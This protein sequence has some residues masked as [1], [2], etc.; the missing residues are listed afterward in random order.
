[1]THTAYILFFTI[2]ILALVAS[3]GYWSYRLWRTKIRHWQTLT[4]L[5]VLY[6]LSIL[7]TGTFILLICNEKDFHE[8]FSVN[9][10]TLGIL[11][12]LPLI[13]LLVK[14]ITEVKVPSTQTCLFHLFP[15]T[16][17]GGFCAFL[18]LSYSAE[19]IMNT[20]WMN[21][22]EVM[23][24]NYL[25]LF[26]SIIGSALIIREVIKY[27]REVDSYFADRKQT[28]YPC[29][30]RMSHAAM[31]NSVMVYTTVLF[32][33]WVCMDNWQLT[34]IIILFMCGILNYLGRTLTMFK[35]S[36]IP[37]DY[38]YS[39][40]ALSIVEIEALE[41][42]FRQAKALIAAENATA[43]ISMIIKEWTEAKNPSYLKTGITLTEAAYEM[44]IPASILSNYINK[45]LDMNFNQWINSFRLK[46]VKYLLITTNKTLDEIAAASGFATRNLLSR[47][48]K[49]H[50]GITPSE[51]RSKKKGS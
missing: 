30:Q 15:T 45:T 12:V 29:V 1:M 7:A 35:G 47:T 2:C 46:H 6:A 17:Y 38:D 8:S 4:V 32:S 9:M 41:N 42:K 49:V 34:G 10:L 21:Q 22:V 25:L 43:N 11:Y 3:A 50:E 51:F 23:L 24:Y 33:F 36:R 44:R 31:V 48:F 16:M 13:Y 37:A 28:D 27:N 26:N 20:P 39:K 40:D 5:Y 19:T 18:H 14:T